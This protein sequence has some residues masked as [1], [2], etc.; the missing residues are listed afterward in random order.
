MQTIIFSDVLYP[1]YGKNAGAYR[2]ATQLR[3]Y[4][5]TCQVIDF[6]SK[7]TSDEIAKIIDKFVTSETIWVGFSTTFMLPSIIDENEGTKNKPEFTGIFDKI[8]TKFEDTRSGFAYSTEIMKE[9]FQYIRGKSNKVKI[10]VGGAR[11]WEAQEFDAVQK[12]VLADYYVHGY[13]DTSIIEL[14][15]WI[16]SDKN[17]KPKF[18]YECVIDSTR[19]Y[20]FTNFNTSNITFL[21]EDLILPNEFLPI[22]IARG[23]IFK[24]KFCTFA[25]VGKKRGDYTKTKEIL[26]NEFMYNYETFGTVNYMF[27]DEITNDSME[28][29]EYLLDV[30]SSLPFKI[31]WGGYAR[32]D[33]FYANPDMASIMQ[34]TGL[35]H[36]FFGIETLNKKS[37]SAVGKGLD[38]DKVKKTL[39]TLKDTWKS[40]VRI[41][42]G[43]IAGLPHET[44]E[45]LQDLENYLLST[46]C[47]LDS[48]SIYPLILTGN[49]LFGQDPSK[50]GYTIDDTDPVIGHFLNWKNNNM[51][52]VEAI[53]IANDIKDNTNHVCKINSW[54]HM[55][56]RNLGYNDTEIKSMTIDSYLLNMP[57]VLKRTQTKKDTYFAHLMSL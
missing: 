6:F 36:V 18:Q 25:L 27:M 23:C 26:V 21:K 1:G 39:L 2:I 7:Y 22:E 41:T 48:W 46:D 44:K 56:L 9:I 37:G 11:T 13:A 20:D 5:Y 54:T 53:K 33:L 49:S 52:F 14:T 47:G 4:G 16:V 10:I 42:A 28:K 57:D 12:G 45:T 31:T 32:I 43:L 40:N 55:R 29:A 35:E 3:N 50:Y 34:E 51:T 30:T 17:P 15:N 19:D 24:C 38:P 8:Y